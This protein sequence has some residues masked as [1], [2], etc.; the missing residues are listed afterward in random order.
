MWGDGTV[1]CGEMELSPVSYWHCPSVEI[2]LHIF[3][4][5]A[6]NGCCYGARHSDSF[7]PISSHGWVKLFRAQW[8]K[9]HANAPSRSQA[10]NVQVYCGILALGP[11]VDLTK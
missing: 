9:K 5:L 1:S 11:G 2:Q 7:Y 4:A 10:R 6:V 3:W 8:L